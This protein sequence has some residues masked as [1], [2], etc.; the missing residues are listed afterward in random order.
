MVATLCDNNSIQYFYRL[1]HISLLKS[2]AYSGIQ[3]QD[4]KSTRTRLFVL[5]VLPAL[6]KA[7]SMGNPPPS[8]PQPSSTPLLS[9]EQVLNEECRR[10]HDRRKHVEELKSVDGSSTQVSQNL[11]GLSFSGGGI[12]S[13]CFSMGIAQAL[14]SRDFFK[15]FDYLSTVSGGGYLGGFLSSWLNQRPQVEKNNPDGDFPLPKQT[16]HDATGRGLRNMIQGGDYI[17]DSVTAFNKYLIGLVLNVTAVFTL[18]LTIACLVALA[19]RLFDLPWVRDLLRLFDLDSDFVA[20]FIPSAI[21]GLSWLLSWMLSYFRRGSLANGGIADR[22]LLCAI[23]SCFIA[24]AL[25]FGNGDVRLPWSSQSDDPAA[26]PRQFWMPFVLAVAIITMLVPVIRPQRLLRSATAPRNIL[27]KWAFRAFSTAV[28]AGIPLIMVGIFGR[29][30]ISGYFDFAERGLHE[31]DF[32]FPK[33]TA[34]LLRSTL[35]EASDSTFDV[36]S[37]LN[38]KGITTDVKLDNLT[39]DVVN[40]AESNIGNPGPWKAWSEIASLIGPADSAIQPDYRDVFSLVGRSGESTSAAGLRNWKIFD[41]NQIIDSKVL[42][43][44]SEGNRLSEAYHNLEL[45]AAEDTDLAIRYLRLLSLRI[46]LASREESVALYQFTHIR[47]SAVPGT[48]VR[49]GL[50]RWNDF[51]IDDYVAQCFNAILHLVLREH[52]EAATWR[53]AAARHLALRTHFA[54]FFSQ[55]LLPSREFTAKFAPVIENRIRTADD[56]KLPDRDTAEMRRLQQQIS[57]TEIGWSSRLEIVSL[58]R[59]LMYHILP[60]ALI[61]ATRV[62]RRIVIE[63][64]QW[65]RLYYSIGLLIV[66]FVIGWGLDINLTSMHRYYRSRLGR[67]FIVTPDPNSPP[68]LQNLDTTSKGGPYHLF[69]TCVSRF[70]IT[71]SGSRLR[72]TLASVNE[73]AA[74]DARQQDT[75][76]MSRD[77]VG[78]EATGGYRRTSDYN[79]L[80][81]D[82]CEK[83]DLHNVI[84]LS[85]AA[86]SPAQ[87]SNPLLAFLMF[88]LNLRLGQWMP[89][90]MLDRPWTRPRF[91]YMLGTTLRSKLVDELGLS[92]Q[93]QQRPYVFISD[94]GHVENLGLLQLLRR[95]CRLIV[96]VDAGHDPQHEFVDV[97]NALRLARIYHGIRCVELTP[98]GTKDTR[99][100]EWSLEKLRLENTA[101]QD[102]TLLTSALEAAGGVSHPLRTKHHFSAARILYPQSSPETNSDNTGLLILVKPSMTG[103]ESPDLL[104]YQKSSPSFPQEPTSELVFSPAQVES[105]RSLG[106][107]IGLELCDLF[108]IKPLHD[109]LEPA[110]QHSPERNS[111]T[112]S[113]HQKE[114]HSHYGGRLSA[115]TIIRAFEANYFPDPLNAESGVS[116]KTA[117]IARCGL[118]NANGT[119]ASETGQFPQ[120]PLFN[121]GPTEAEIAEKEQWRK[122]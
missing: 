58:N 63:H 120:C 40:S 106:Y 57:R 111:T 41:L 2:L 87:N 116:G 93:P 26:I 89:N 84:A 119:Q 32:K 76:L 118:L 107:H 19:W 6:R 17:V 108:Q 8:D 66:T 97:A 69:G 117:T 15:A 121:S 20:P 33:L 50:S 22:L 55:T 65:T 122:K 60:D 79:Q 62:Q 94:G 21:L 86:V 81:I 68:L 67:A 53:K 44:I 61:P 91:L 85:G 59:E 36:L 47:P 70:S 25:L 43:D 112:E 99:E 30:N 12:R 7:H 115:T 11:V 104:Q 78:S 109:N 88:A 31:A 38:Q 48:P 37:F 102:A 28:L 18:M 27:D 3:G 45:S 24:L 4:E 39:D 77:F 80:T 10:I 49:F 9:F 16:M 54:D 74:W 35:P 29:E 46:L 114:D 42:A 105:Y 82:R 5:P 100:K 90:P 101:T 98:H 34:D 52:G 64:D 75:F 103:D 51:T 73:S 96:A 83:L 13:A 72:E 92:R 56:L 71:N 113:V 110:A 1:F 23:G 95:R 14:N